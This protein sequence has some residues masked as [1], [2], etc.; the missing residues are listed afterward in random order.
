MTKAEVDSIFEVSDDGGLRT[1]N[2]EALEKV[3]HAHGKDAAPLRAAYKEVFGDGL[4]ARRAGMKLISGGGDIDWAE[5]LR[6]LDAEQKPRGRK[7][8]K[9]KPA[10]SRKKA[11]RATTPTVVMSTPTV[12]VQTSRTTRPR[13]QGTRRPRAMPP[14]DEPLVVAVEDP[15][16]EAAEQAD[17]NASDGGYETDEHL[18]MFEEEYVIDWLLAGGF[19]AILHAEMGFLPLQED[20]DHMANII[21]KLTLRPLF[22]FTVKASQPVTFKVPGWLTA[23]KN[24]SVLREWRIMMAAVALAET[25]GVR[26]IGF[27]VLYLHAENEAPRLLFACYGEILHDGEAGVL[28]YVDSDRHQLPMGLPKSV[29]SA[30]F[31]AGM[32]NLVFKFARCGVCTM[33]IG[34]CSPDWLL[35]TDGRSM[36]PSCFLLASSGKKYAKKLPR[37]LSPK[38]KAQLQ[39]REQVERTK[40]LAASVYPKLLKHAFLLGLV[41]SDMLIPSRIVVMPGLGGFMPL[42][43]DE[44]FTKELQVANKKRLTQAMARHAAGRIQSSASPL[45]DAAL[46]VT[47]AEAPIFTMTY[48]TVPDALML[49]SAELIRPVPVLQDN[50]FCIARQTM[51]KKVI[52]DA[53]ATEALPAGF[54]SRGQLARNKLRAVYLDEQRSP[55]SF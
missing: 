36:Y 30:I 45:A 2:S 1:I 25:S 19:Y 13:T 46:A 15:E 23:R 24:E 44:L 26:L 51:F 5:R 18:P 41:P 42:F 10:K 20:R 16:E 27:E 53:L 35:S 40:Q 9:V 32:L 6:P 52:E 50:E 31:R 54:N 55:L 21:P 28:S 29:A 47:D 37:G 8:S 12:S 17:G 38:E 43:P 22:D 3:L 34:A 39:E 7:S 49:A 48:L 11:K 4:E 33:S 14:R